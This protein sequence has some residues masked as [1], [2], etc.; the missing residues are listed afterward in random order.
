V[1]HGVTLDV[2]AGFSDWIAAAQIMARAFRRIGIE[3][4]VRASEYSAWFE[5]LESGSFDLAM[6]WSDLNVT[7]YGFYRSLMATSTVNVTSAA[8]TP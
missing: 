2:P 4:T 8:A 7:P 3:I 6:A 5:K 1:L